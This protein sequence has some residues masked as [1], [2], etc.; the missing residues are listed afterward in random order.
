MELEIKDLQ[1][2]RN[3]IESL[4]ENQKNKIHAKLGVFEDQFWKDRQDRIIKLIG[5]AVY[6]A[7]FI[8]FLFH[9]ISLTLNY[10]SADPLFRE[11]DISRNHISFT[12]SWILLLIVFTLAK[13]P[14]W[15]FLYAK[16]VPFLVF[17][18]IT[19]NATVLL[20]MYSLSLAWRGSIVVTLTI[21]FVY[22]FSGLKP[23]ITLI[24]NVCAGIVIYSYF[25]CTK[26][27]IA[28][29]I[30][31]NTLI[32]PN[33]VGLALAILSS[34][35]EKIRFLQSKIIDYDKQ[36]YELMNQQSLDLSQQ[37]PLTLLGNR[38]GFEEK[39]KLTIEETNTTKFP[40]ALLFIDID[41]F[42]F[43]N[44]VYGHDAGDQA[45]KRVALTLKRSIG[46]N[47]L[48]IRF[49]GEEF[50]VLLNQTNAHYSEI[51]AKVILNDIYDQ[52]IEHR[53][54]LIAPYLTMS[55]GIAIYDGQR[56]YT[57]AEVL[58]CAD[59]ALY[60]AKHMG[61]NRYQRLDCNTDL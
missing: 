6:V 51:I 30:L 13:N 35:T 60:M 19:I 54:S 47:D 56:K 53:Q 31:A 43:Y 20:S 26:F 32:L 3:E 48:A 52:K 12:V 55:I 45:L 28:G 33:L 58:K 22:I 24:A 4:L 57:Y 29:W 18:G 15:H 16:V 1:K 36:I 42:K 38:R 7:I 50:I 46:P 49:G 44:D 23:K 37:D 5:R 17:F 11:R 8:Y 10:L 40:F 25:I 41:Y 14:A 9:S 34:S 61:R 39:L 2:Q 27:E 59:N 21:V